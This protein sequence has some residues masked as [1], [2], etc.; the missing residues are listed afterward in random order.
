MKTL[1]TFSLWLALC[2]SLSA[3]SNLLTL[4]AS[5]RNPNYLYSTDNLPI[6]PQLGFSR[7]FGEEL[8]LQA[9]VGVVVS[10]FDVELS[11]VQLFQEQELTT[12]LEVFALFPILRRWNV[13]NRLRGGIG[14][15]GSRNNYTYLEEAIIVNNQVTSLNIQDPIYYLHSL[16]VKAEYVQPISQKFFLSASTGLNVSLNRLPAYES[17]LVEQFSSGG[18]GTSTYSVDERHSVNYTFT[19]AVGYAL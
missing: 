10:K 13:P 14:Y 15:I 4:G 16:G 2:F 11:D 17:V 19:L 3:Q 8:W 7:L 18:T 6:G 9:N 1:L 12:Y 5:Y